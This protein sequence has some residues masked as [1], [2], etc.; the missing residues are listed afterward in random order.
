M[1][2]EDQ[3]LHAERVVVTVEGDG[4]INRLVDAPGSAQGNA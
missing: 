3:K 2:Q 4:E 1:E